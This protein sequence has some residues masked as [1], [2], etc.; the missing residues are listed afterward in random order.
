MHSG[1]KVHNK[2]ALLGAECVGRRKAPTK[3]ESGA[4]SGRRNCSYNRTKCV[5]H[6]LSFLGLLN[7]VLASHSLTHTHRTHGQLSNRIIF[8]CNST[9]QIQSFHR[10]LSFHSVRC[11][12]S[13]FESDPTAHTLSHTHTPSIH[14]GHFPPASF[15]FP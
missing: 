5:I 3:A 2:T 6:R 11:G 4:S 12:R 8:I 14:S 13:Q 15:L 7:G 10:S 1:P 9:Q